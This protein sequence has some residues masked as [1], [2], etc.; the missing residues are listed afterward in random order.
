M[1]DE[2]FAV[3]TVKELDDILEVSGYAAFN[4]GKLSDRKKKSLVRALRMGVMPSRSG[5]ISTLF[6]CICVDYGLG[7]IYMSTGGSMKLVTWKVPVA[8][9]EDIKAMIALR[10]DTV[11]GIDYNEAGNNFKASPYKNGIV[12]KHTKLGVGF[13][14]NV[15]KKYDN[16]DKARLEHVINMVDRGGSLAVCFGSDGNPDKSKMFTMVNGVKSWL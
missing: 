8:V 3:S 4:L 14:R 12:C 1:L 9:E 10:N 16:R 13:I 7:H 11:Q 5:A 6:R 2:C 15:F